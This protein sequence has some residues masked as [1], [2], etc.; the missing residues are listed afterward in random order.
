MTNF[1]GNHKY[2]I[3][4]KSALWEWL[5]SLQTEGQPIAMQL[6]VA[7]R[8]C[9]AKAPKSCLRTSQNNTL[10]SLYGVRRLIM[11]HSRSA[12][13]TSPVASGRRYVWVALQACVGLLSIRTEPFCGTQPCRVNGFRTSGNPSFAISGIELWPRKLHCIYTTW[14]LQIIST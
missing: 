9:Y 12:R 14:N 7:F 3:F 5:C 13:I 10:S 2:K 6:V 1:G 11:F 8:N 4:R